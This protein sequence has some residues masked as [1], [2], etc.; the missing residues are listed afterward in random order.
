MVEWWLSGA[1]S[2][3][4]SEPKAEAT[5]LAPKQSADRH[6]PLASPSEGFVLAPSPIPPC[7][8]G[9]RQQAPPPWH[10]ARTRRAGRFA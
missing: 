1:G 9:S 3:R 7:R 6:D 2:R 4:S 8:A 10:Q 5:G